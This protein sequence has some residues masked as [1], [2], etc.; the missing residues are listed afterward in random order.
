MAVRGVARRMAAVA[1]VG[2]LLGIAPAIGADAASAAS[3]AIGYNGL[4][5]GTKVNVAGSVVS[6]RSFPVYMGCS[7]NSDQAHE[8][9][10]VGVD[11]LGAVSTG[12]IDN[13]AGSSFHQS[14]ATSKVATVDI[15]GGTIT[16]DSVT[17]TATEQFASGTFTG[18][19]DS[20]IASLMV[21][22]TPVAVNQPPNTQVALPGIGTLTINEQ[23]QTDD[24]TSATMEVR[25]LHLRV[26]APNNP[27]A[28]A[29]GT[30][31]IVADAR[32]GLVRSP[33]GLLDGDAYGSRVSVSG[34]VTSGRSANLSMPCLGTDGN[35]I[36]N[37]S[38]GVSA[39]G[40]L[41][42]GTIT[43]TAEGL[44]GRHSASG[45][46]TNEVQSVDV[47][48]LVTADAVKADVLADNSGGSRQFTD[49]STFTDL[50][51]A[52]MPLIGD[53]VPANTTVAIPMVGTLYLHRVITSGNAM[54]VR[55]IELV[56]TASG[57]PFPVG[58]D[59][60][61]GVARISLH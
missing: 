28:L 2:A 60:V 46:M 51:V 9:T 40:A 41:D 57:T 53:Q 48:G 27:L 34:A 1:V 17:A 21:N 32:A 18:S 30:N 33:G 13:T 6:G 55:M 19:G 25:A 50:Q 54:Q 36:T 12:A 24:G 11:V 38:A 58:T 42:T 47:A 3:S 56:V 16:A 5:F 10:G 31:I 43:S 8:N 14:T 15:G 29:V 23:I 44:V 26:N 22:G 52:G 4:A 59:I 35:T 61:V 37:T 7:T 20:S 49:Q 45:E 39:A